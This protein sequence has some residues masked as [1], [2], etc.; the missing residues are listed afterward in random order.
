MH[1]SEQVLQ[2]KAAISR[3]YHGQCATPGWP[4]GFLTTSAPTPAP[5]ILT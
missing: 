2:R 3:K 4:M 1:E 5:A